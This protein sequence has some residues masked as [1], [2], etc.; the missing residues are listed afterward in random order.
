MYT[1][2][3]VPMRSQQT[4]SVVLNPESAVAGGRIGRR[5]GQVSG[6]TGWFTR[7]GC[8]PGRSAQHNCRLHE[9]EQPD[10]RPTEVPRN[11]RPAWPCPY[12]GKK[13]L[14]K[15][16]LATL[17]SRRRSGERATRSCEG[18]RSSYRRA[19]EEMSRDLSLYNRY[20]VVQRSSEYIST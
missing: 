10:T 12:H 5:I 2:P 20:S 11:V 6:C 17:Q 16:D 4:D 7:L 15:L 1:S 18:S 8:T 14:G 3:R 13:Y 9:E 19:C